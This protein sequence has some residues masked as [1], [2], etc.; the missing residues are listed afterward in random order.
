MQAWNKTATNFMKE[1]YR[2]FKKTQKYTNNSRLC[3]A[4]SIQ[5]RSS[6]QN[7]RKEVEDLTDIY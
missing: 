3:I 2:L 5:D 1:N 4:L 7:I 6:G